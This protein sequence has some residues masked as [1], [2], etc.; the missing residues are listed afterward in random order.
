MVARELKGYIFACL[1]N[2]SLLIVELVKERI[3]LMSDALKLVF[4][5]FIFTNKMSFS[6]I[7]CFYFVNSNPL[8]F[9]FQTLKLK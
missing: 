1:N 8:F 2:D 5:K 6:L 9:Q 3:M 7:L 4:I